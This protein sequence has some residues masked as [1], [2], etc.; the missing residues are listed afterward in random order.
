MLKDINF[1][2]L[3]YKTN[4]IIKDGSEEDLRSEIARSTGFP[5]QYLEI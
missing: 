4:L 1:V 3:N 2:N 5:A